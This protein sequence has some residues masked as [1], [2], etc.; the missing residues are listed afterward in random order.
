[1]QKPKRTT[2]PGRKSHPLKGNAVPLSLRMYPIDRRYLEF[3]HATVTQALNSLCSGY[4]YQ[5]YLQQQLELLTAK[6]GK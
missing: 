5:I 3:K 2:G 6:G 4:E 1:M